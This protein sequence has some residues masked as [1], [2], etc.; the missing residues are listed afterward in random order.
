MNFYIQHAPFF[1]FSIIRIMTVRIYERIMWAKSLEGFS[2]LDYNYFKNMYAYGKRLES[3]F[4]YAQSYIGKV[5]LQVPFSLHKIVSLLIQCKFNENYLK[6]KYLP[7]LE[8]NDWFW[9]FSEPWKWCRCPKRGWKTWVWHQEQNR[10]CSP[11]VGLH[12]SNTPSS[13][14]VPSQR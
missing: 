8:N 4:L 11:R 3:K 10:S 2:K 6:L 7:W 13:T 5:E 9:I 14:K 1:H 12:V